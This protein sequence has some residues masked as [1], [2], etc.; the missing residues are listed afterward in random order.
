VTE[1]HQSVAWMARSA[2]EQ[3]GVQLA[4][5]RP[6]RTHGGHLALKET[7]SDNLRIELRHSCFEQGVWVVRLLRK[8][9]Y[10]I[11]ISRLSLN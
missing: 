5:R 1:R 4:Q 10:Y 2:A 3:K 7:H 8:L 11:I 6:D 9:L